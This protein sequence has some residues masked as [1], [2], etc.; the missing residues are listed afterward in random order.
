MN[1]LL[2]ERSNRSLRTHCPIMIRKHVEGNHHEEAVCR[3]D[4][5]DLKQKIHPSRCGS[6]SECPVRTHLQERKEKVDS[7][8]TLL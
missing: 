2:Q 7:V 3:C 4:V 1:A 6:R 5:K 8:Y